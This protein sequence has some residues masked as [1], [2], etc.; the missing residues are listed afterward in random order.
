MNTYYKRL[1][2]EIINFNLK[3]Q[4]EN[5]I[6]GLVNVQDTL[7]DSIDEFVI[8]VFNDNQD[9]YCINRYIECTKED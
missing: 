9:S 4:A 2:V 7:F 6:R 8:E 5:H 3:L 1:L